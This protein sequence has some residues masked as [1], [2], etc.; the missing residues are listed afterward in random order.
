MKLEFFRQIFE[1]YSN[2][3]FRRNPF[4]GRRVVLFGRRDRNDEASSF[5][6]QLRERA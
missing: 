4:S 5:F 2:I 6:S 3:K 1:K